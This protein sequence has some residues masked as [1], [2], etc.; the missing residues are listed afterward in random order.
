MRIVAHVPCHLSLTATATDP[1]PAYSP[2]L[3]SRLVLQETQA[4]K[5]Q[6]VQNPRNRNLPKNA[7]NF[8]IWSKITSYYAL[9]ICMEQ[10]L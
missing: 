8:T 5:P 6:K 1:P 2:T 3:Q 9:H 4:K 7:V 10:N